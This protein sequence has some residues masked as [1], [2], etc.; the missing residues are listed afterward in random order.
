MSDLSL[1]KSVPVAVLGAGAVGKTC[2]ADCVLGG[3]TD[4]RLFELPEFFEQNLKYVHKT[5][6]TLGGI[7][8]NQYGFRRTGKAYI[9]KLTSDIS[10]AV[11]GAK[12]IIVAIPSVA[13]DKFFDRLVPVLEDG[14][15]IHIIPDNYGSLKL[16]KK[17]REQKSDK[18]VIIGGWSSAPYGTRVEKEGGVQTSEMW[19]VYRAK[20][21]RGASLPSTDQEVFLESSKYLGCFDSITEGDGAVGGKTVLDI[22]FSN[23]NPVLHCPGTILGVGVMENFGRIYGGNDPKQYSI[24]SHAYCNSISE[25]QYAFFLE[26]VALADAIGV[27]IAKYPKKNFFSRTSIL[28]PEYMGDDC[29]VPF[30][31]QWETGYT[32]GPF[33]IQDR[34]VTEDVPV[35]CHLYHELGLRYNV[36]TP[37]IDSMITLGSVMTGKDF[38]ATGLTLDDLGIGHLGS[39]ELL[40]YLEN[41]VYKEP[42]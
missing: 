15:I 37:V 34:Y 22:G 6:I 1:D 18:K 35:G 24:Y 19:L 23:V 10:E 20:T 41:G 2:A 36:P 3:N 17:M 30:D 9:H 14:Q 5:G 25:V 4:V 8:K 13:H 31:E 42:A 11:A 40:D 29:I 12:I 16:R 21:L 38:Y 27:G 7:Q 32:T 33:T 26:E 39:R 28:G